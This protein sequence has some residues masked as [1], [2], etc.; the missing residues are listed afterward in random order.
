MTNEKNE[1]MKIIEPKE[2]M[3]NPKRVAAGR[4]GAEARIRNAEQRK[5]EIETIR[6]EN[7]NLKITKDDDD[8]KMNLPTEKDFE[9]NF[10][11]YIPVFIIVGLSGIGL[12][13]YTKKQEKLE[14]PKRSEELIRQ[15]EK[16]LK[17]ETS[18]YI[19]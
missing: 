19:W 15:E 9:Y 6:K 18:N 7:I 12:Y 13:F 2:K 17:E 5:K 8:E 4:K 14:K 11:D 3:K 16:P 10:K 1:E